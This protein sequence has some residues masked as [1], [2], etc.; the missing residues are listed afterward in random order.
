MDIGSH[1]HS[2]PLLAHL[3]L[4]LR[5]K[6]W[7][8]PRQSWNPS[9]AGTISAVAYPEGGKMFYNGATTAIARRLGYRL[10]FSFTRHINRLPLA[11]PLQIGRF[12]VSEEP[13]T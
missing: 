5:S 1:T 9:C 7:P 11:D 4:K 3:D 2:H 10:G 13:S 8:S 12:A 6:S